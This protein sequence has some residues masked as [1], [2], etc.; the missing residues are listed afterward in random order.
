M[1]KVIGVL[2]LIAISILSGCV[3]DTK[4]DTQS[5]IANS[6]ISDK[7]GTDSGVTDV[8]DANDKISVESGNTYANT[9]SGIGSEWCAPGATITI[10]DN[11][12]FVV[13]GITTYTTKDG[14]VH[15]GV[16]KAEKS[17]PGGSSVAYFNE[18]Y[19]NDGNDKLIVVEASANGSN[20]HASSS[21][22]VKS[23]K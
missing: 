15:D 22:T 13:V 17:I 18:G 1:K 16:C 23:G 14:S 2:L 11:G 9:V 10:G 5:S 6:S 20:A 3:T 4:D 19:I 21:V 8:V 12:D 7:P